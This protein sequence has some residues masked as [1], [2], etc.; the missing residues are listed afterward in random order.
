ML[1]IVYVDICSLEII[2]SNDM[3]NVLGVVTFCRDSATP[4]AA[5]EGITGA[6]SNE[7]ADAVKCYGNRDSLSQEEASAC[8]SVQFKI[9]YIHIIMPRC[10]CAAKHTVVTLCVCVCVCSE[11][12]CFFRGLWAQ[13][14]VSMDLILCF[15][16]MQFADLQ[17]KAL[18]LR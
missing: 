3:N 16:S 4:V 13:V 15:L 18:F 17:D 14:S 12:I 2:C 5:E 10:A 11:R 7:R 8:M 1:V 9:S 6:L